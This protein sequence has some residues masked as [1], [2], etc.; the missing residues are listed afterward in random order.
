[1]S[2]RRLL[3][4]LAHK[5]IR[6]INSGLKVE[7]V[8]VMEEAT[9]LNDQPLPAIVSPIYLTPIGTLFTLPAGAT[10]L[11]FVYA[12]ADFPNGA[13][14]G[15]QMP[16]GTKYQAKISN[17]QSSGAR[18]FHGYYQINETHRKYLEGQC[19]TDQRI[20]EAG[21]H[22]IT[23]V[24]RFKESGKGC[25]IELVKAS[26][27]LPGKQTI[28]YT[29]G[30]QQAIPLT[31]SYT[32]GE[33]LTT[34]AYTR[35]C[36]EQMNPLDAYLKENQLQNWLKAKGMKGATIYLGD[37]TIGKVTEVTING[38][39]A[40]SLTTAQAQQKVAGKAFSGDYAIYACIDKDG[41]W[42]VV[43]NFGKTALKPTHTKLK[44]KE[45]V[46]E[47]EVRKQAQEEIK[48]RNAQ[49]GGTGSR[50]SAEEKIVLGED[51]EFYKE[52][53][54]IVEAIAA[55]YDFGK[56]VINEAKLPE[57][58]WNQ[59]EKPEEY[60]KSPFHMPSLLAGG[61]DQVIDEVTEGVQF[62]QLAYQVVRKPKETVNGLWKAVKKIK[63][64]DIRKLIVTDEAIAKY[65]KGGDLSKH[66]G[67]KDGV[68][69][70]MTVM[71]IWKAAGKSG[72]E[73]LEKSG[74]EVEELK[75][76]WLRKEKISTYCQMHVK[77]L[78][79]QKAMEWK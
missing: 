30:A 29:C 3:V 28:A 32:A 22:T 69:I 7:A 50:K 61:S 48:E 59:Q 5:D 24:Q 76:F 13:L 39:Q 1:V 46:L 79:L 25:G 49:A 60:N 8:P 51:G 40:S 75:D 53:M 36:E 63:P 47:E 37:C 66:Q 33:V 16:D 62:V 74:D 26:Y 20:Y 21:T 34:Y 72:K 57:G 6:N 78:G 45:K 55:V 67:G 12:D 2:S 68:R 19:Y 18:V 54:G 11:D 4:K 44:G 42:Q 64:G 10:V 15:F 70:A 14:L 52:S 38:Q 43:S 27:I 41:K 77:W 35:R 71:V 17:R 9:L 23:L 31:L 56:E 73:I 65:Q 58:T